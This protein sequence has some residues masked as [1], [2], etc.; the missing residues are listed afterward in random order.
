M[1]MVHLSFP[2]F[3][4]PSIRPSIHLP[5]TIITGVTEFWPDIWSFNR[6]TPHITTTTTTI[7][8][9]MVHALEVKNGNPS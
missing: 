6:A 9:I 7:I 8:I 3:L 5:S 2:P 1:Y 4:P